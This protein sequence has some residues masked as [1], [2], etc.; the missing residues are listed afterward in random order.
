MHLDTREKQTA[1]TNTSHGET[2]MS[3][4]YPILSCAK[5]RELLL[6][7]AWW[8]RKLRTG[9]SKYSQLTKN[10]AIVPAETMRR[11]GL[12]AI[13][14]GSNICGERHIFDNRAKWTGNRWLDSF[15][16]PRCIWSAFLSSKDPPF[17]FERAARRATWGR[18]GNTSCQLLYILV[19]TR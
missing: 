6:C 19:V 17:W 2:V 11:S 16:M 7:M 10:I 1:H 4:I 9:T 12:N 15:N 8:N 3:V 13:S 14:L 18:G 5:V